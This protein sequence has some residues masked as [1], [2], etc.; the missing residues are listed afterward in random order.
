MHK[1]GKLFV[2]LLSLAALML[3]GCETTPRAPG[4]KPASAEEAAKAITSGEFVR[5][6]HEFERLAQDAIAPRKQHYQL[7]AV[8]LYLKAAQVSEAHKKIREIDVSALAPSFK[9]RKRV[10]QGQLAASEG[11]YARAIIC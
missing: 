1:K 4:A 2:I 6:A 3:A 11:N 8:E 10:L 7:R 5:A 9:A